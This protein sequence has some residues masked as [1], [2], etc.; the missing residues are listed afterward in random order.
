M[1]YQGKDGKV[2]DLEYIYGPIASTWHYD[3]QG[4]VRDGN[5]NIISDDRLGQIKTWHGQQTET[6]DMINEYNDIAKKTAAITGSQPVLKGFSGYTGDTSATKWAGVESDYEQVKK[7]LNIA[8]QAYS[9]ADTQKSTAEANKYK[10]QMPTEWQTVEDLASSTIK[11][12]EPTL[13]PDLV[14]QWE[15]KLETVYSPVRDKVKKNMADYWASLFPQGGGS[16][17][18][19]ELN[20]A[21]LADIETNKFN[22]S[23]GFAQTDLANKLAAYQDAK[24]KLLGIGTFKAQADQFKSSQDAVNAWQMMNL[25]WTKNKY[26]MDTANNTKNYN[27]NAALAE[28]LASIVK[29][30]QSN[31]FIDILPSLIQAGGQIGAASIMPV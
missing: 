19:V 7:D 20:Q 4:K 12:G 16:G 24:E 17:K 5:H 3:A 30:K 10:F 13:N 23:L 27:Q 1:A 14:N 6:E 22:Q 28:Y 11:Q 15:Q 31:P 18:Q 26:A 8:K 25:D 2:T 21:D 29:P 9:F